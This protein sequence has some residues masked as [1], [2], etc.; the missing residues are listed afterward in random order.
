MSM[1]FYFGVKINYQILDLSFPLPPSPSPFLL[2]PF[3]T[4]L[5]QSPLPRSP[6]FRIPSCP[7]FRISSFLNCFKHDFNCF[8]C[9]SVFQRV[10]ISLW[11][12]DPCRTLSPIY[13]PSLQAHNKFNDNSIIPFRSSATVFPPSQVPCSENLPLHG[14]DDAWV[15]LC[16]VL[17]SGSCHS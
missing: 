12:W 2:F 7:L 10:E 6:T 11:F 8:G 5:S 14:M 3:P 9:L 15:R 16:S 1:W 4:S 13:E 17:V